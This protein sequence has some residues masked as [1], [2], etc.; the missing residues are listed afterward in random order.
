MHVNPNLLALHVYPRYWGKD[1]LQ[2]RPSRW[3]M[4]PS[5]SDPC[6]NPYELESFYVPPKGSFYPFSEGAR[7]CPG[8]KFAQVEHVAVIATLFQK[9]Q[10][11]PVLQ[12]GESMDQALKRIMEVVNDRGMVLLM[13]ILHPE[14]GVLEWRKASRTWRNMIFW[15]L[16]YFLI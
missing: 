7:S 6:T 3:I 16:N 10:V 5:S 15:S 4:S 1:S 13:Q 14:K 2:W 9:H 12:A 11:Q 8:K